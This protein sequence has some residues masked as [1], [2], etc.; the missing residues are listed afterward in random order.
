[1]TS[2]VIE[3]TW[4]E[5]L[6]SL[7]DTPVNNVVVASQQLHN[8]AV[9]DVRAESVEL[10]DGQTVRREFV[11]HTGAVGVLALDDLD[12]VLLIRQYRHPVGM[13]LWEPVAGLLDMA[14][15][16]PRDGAA[17]EL[18]EEAGLIAHD[19]HT[20][21][22]FETSPGG[23]S[24]TIRMYLARGLEPVPGGRPVGTGE[25][26]D[27]PLVW[28]PLEQVVEKVLSGEFTCPTTVVGALAAWA[29]RQTGWS[30]LRP[31]SAPWASRAHVV[32]TGRTRQQ[33]SVEPPLGA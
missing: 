11:V 30:S 8:G 1:M 12:R 32:E 29:H 10:G 21:V 33:V 13:M 15:E 2:Y 22:D 19:W 27:L 31:A 18:V 6:D 5:P 23:S 26:R 7:R 17:R 16:P 28:V 9:W 3:P 14:D 25:E 24:E 20:L 4:A